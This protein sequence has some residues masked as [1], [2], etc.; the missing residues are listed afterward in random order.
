MTNI[1]DLEHARMLVRDLSGDS[2]RD[3]IDYL[4]EA[5]R[6]LLDAAI[7]AADPY[8]TEEASA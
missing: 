1:H 6:V 3:A 8:A 2:D 4:G 5:V 7:E